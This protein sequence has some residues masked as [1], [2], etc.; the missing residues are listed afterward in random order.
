MLLLMR[1][2]VLL[3][4]MAAFL[5]AGSVVR[6]AVMVDQT[7]STLQTGVPQLTLDDFEPL[8]ALVKE[9]GGELACSARRSTD[10]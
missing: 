4:A 1:A 3:A 2:L 6:I 7:G 8:I 10:D 9:G 5:V